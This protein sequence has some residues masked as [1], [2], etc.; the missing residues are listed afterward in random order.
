M[1]LMRGIRSQLTSLIDGLEES[2]L[3]SM[4][5]G[6]AHRCALATAAAAAAGPYSRPPPALSLGRYKLKFSPDKVDTMIVQAIGLLD[7]LDKEINTYR[8]ERRGCA[9]L[10]VRADP[11]APYNLST[12]PPT[13]CV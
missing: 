11:A 2:Q 10:A 4:Y 5:L 3:R 13:A 9:S 12:P 6:L 1:E 7:E 8:C